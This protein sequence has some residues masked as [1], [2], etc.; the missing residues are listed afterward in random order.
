MVEF[1]I[2][3]RLLASEE[4]VADALHRRMLQQELER[5]LLISLPLSVDG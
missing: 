4:F 5:N 3:L 2:A 1:W